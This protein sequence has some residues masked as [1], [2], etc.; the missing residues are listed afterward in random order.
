[1]PQVIY[2]KM[3]GVPERNAAQQ[4]MM[5]VMFLDQSVHGMQTNVMTDLWT[6][7]DDPIVEGNPITGPNLTHL[8]NRPIQGQKSSA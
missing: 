8:T 4:M 6:C 2:P 1:M 5:T 7:E 3:R